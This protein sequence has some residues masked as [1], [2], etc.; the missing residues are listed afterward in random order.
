MAGRL[1]ASAPCLCEAGTFRSVWVW[2]ALHCKAATASEPSVPL[3][4]FYTT[5]KQFEPE[6]E[7]EPEQSSGNNTGTCPR[8]H[9]H[10]APKLHLG[11]GRMAGLW[12]C[13][14]AMLGSLN[15]LLALQTLWELS[16]TLCGGI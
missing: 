16:I 5:A 2:R 3:F 10:S 8:A 7:P 12:L 11:L 4:N 6:P 13:L 1:Q 14:V 15:L 9:K